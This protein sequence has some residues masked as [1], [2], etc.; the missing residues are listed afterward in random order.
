MLLGLVGAIERIEIGRELDLGVA[1][2]R[3]IRRHAL[4]DLDRQLRLLH[5]L[6][7]IG[8]RQQRQRMVGREIERELQIDEAEI[9]A[10]AAAERG[11]E[12]VERFGGA[13]LRR[14]TSGGNFLPALS[15]S[16]ASTTSGWRGN[17]LVEGLEDLERLVLGVPLRDS[18]LP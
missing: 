13:G 6:V 15:L 14:S 16:I 7:E 12:A 5:L 11:A 2:Q 4:V 8:E 17:A 18:Q 3:R 10:A 1:L 9:L